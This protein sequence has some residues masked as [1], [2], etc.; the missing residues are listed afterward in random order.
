MVSMINKKNY[1]SVIIKYP[2]LSGAL[3]AVRYG[4]NT[5]HKP[6]VTQEPT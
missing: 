3:I 4:Y 6:A 5:I 2:L 1:P